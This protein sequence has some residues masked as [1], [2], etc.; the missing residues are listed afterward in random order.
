[1]IYN[2]CGDAECVVEAGSVSLDENAFCVGD[3]VDDFVTATITG[4][5]GTFSQIIVT[6]TASVITDLPTTN[7]F[8]VNG[9]S[10]TCL[11]WNLV[12]EFPINLQIG[13]N[14]SN[15]DST[16]F[17]LSGAAIF[18]KT[19]VD[20]GTVSLESGDTTFDICVDD[21]NPNVLTFINT[22]SS[23]ANYRYVITDESNVILA[24]P[25][26]DNFDFEELEPGICRVWGVSLAG[27][28]GLGVGEVFDS[29]SAV[30]NCFEISD[31]FI[32]V[33]KFDSG[34]P[35]MLAICPEGPIDCD[36]TDV[37]VIFP[38]TTLAP[39]SSFCIPMIVENFTDISTLQ[40][41]FSWDPAV[42]SFTGS[43]SYSLPGM[44]AG[45]INGAVGPGVGS[46]VWFDLSG[47]NPQDLDDGSVLFEIC[48]DVIGNDNDQTYLEVVETPNA[49]IQF[50]NSA[51]Q[52]LNT[53][54]DGGCIEIQAQNFTLF[55]QNVNVTDS[56]ACVDILAVNFTEISGQQYAIQ[57]DST[58]MCLDSIINMNTDIFVLPNQFNQPSSDRIRYVWTG[59]GNTVP[60]GDILY[61]LCFDVKDPSCGMGTDINF[62]DD[63]VPIEIIGTNSLI[64]FDISNG[65]VN[66]YS[67]GGDIALNND[68]TSITVCVGDGMSDN[69][70]YFTNSTSLDNYQWVITDVNN[71][72]IDIPM[73]AS[74]DFESS[75]VG[76]CRIWGVSHTGSF[77]P[78]IGDVLEDILD[79][80]C[81]GVS[82]NFIEVNKVDNGPSC[83][84]PQPIGFDIIPNPAFDN[85]EVRI[86]KMPNEQSAIHIVNSIGENIYKEIMN[87]NFGKTEIDVSQFP[88]GV[89]FLIL[90]SGDYIMTKRFIV[91]E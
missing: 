30:S 9:T 29:N 91:I 88:E 85:L 2:L 52:T 17:D 39:G 73:G 68:A 63:L 70:G 51:G 67:D 40:G 82:A 65:S 58:F 42:L 74:Y 3:N 27:G 48:F 15:I 18:T 26:G 46:F 71:V 62:I 43:Q 36:S 16:C 66:Y 20:G 53:C 28:F 14:F 50:T 59:F 72:I 79:N 60:D 90:K 11:V 78:S 76:V 56:S 45:S 86:N 31:N 49:I 41:G 33:E 77:D 35:C 1:M 25:S 83:N 4:Q 37:I 13:N 69:L 87:P 89:Y 81:F 57:W 54:L 8:E 10:G 64:P 44:N 23:T 47:A 19:S 6:N 24:V 84:S 32:E 38:D 61:T 80:D 55:A 5:M 12:S 22:S 7:T 34:G 75:A 21:G